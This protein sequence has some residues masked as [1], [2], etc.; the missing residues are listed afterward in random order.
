MMIVLLVLDIFAEY[1]IEL[2][3]LRHNE[4]EVLF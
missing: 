2:T 1:G 4:L 3:Y